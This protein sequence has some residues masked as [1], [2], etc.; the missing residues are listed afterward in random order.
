M[1]V[2]YFHRKRELSN[3]YSLEEYFSVVRGL[4]PRVIETRVATSRFGSR[5]VWRRIY[6]AA[7]A[8]PRQGDINHVTGDAQYLT[9]VL[10]PRRTILTIAD[11]GFEQRPAGLR[12]EMVRLLWYTLPVRRAT[13]VTVI[14]EFTRQRLLATVPCDASK[15]R[16]I[17]VCISPAFKPAPRRE[18]PARPTVL[19]IGTAPNKNLDRLGAAVAGL[20]CR[21]RVIGD[22][23]ESQRQALA[24]HRVEYTAASHLTL[25]QM[26]DEYRQADLVT[27]P[28]TYE[29]FGM[30]IVEANAVG[31]P[32]LTSQVASMPEVAGDAA[33][34]V[35]PSSVESIRDGLRRLFADVSLRDS[36][37]AR[38]FANAQRFDRAAI[39]RAF[40]RLYGEVGGVSPGFEAGGLDSP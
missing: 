16:V 24:A 15:V 17:P 3:H 12:R 13:A 28:S 31:R 21:L 23:S 9:L 35:D 40:A 1:T 10:G 32:V 38:G 26:V 14:S 37:V 18:W 4:L 20:D 5:G 7:E 36:L 22:L 33:V 39:A 34:L 27:L 8:V 19:Q 2:V 25:D 6:N 30:P 29:G 11:C